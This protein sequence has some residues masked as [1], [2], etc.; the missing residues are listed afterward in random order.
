MYL[1]LLLPIISGFIAQTIKFFIKTNQQNFSFKKIAAYS[2]MPSG[3]SAMVV[4]LTAIAGLQEGF[5]SPIFAISLILAIIV[6]RDALGIR[7]YLGIHGKTLNILVKD[8]KEDKELF[9]S[10]QANIAVCFQDKYARDVI[11]YK[12]RG[13]IHKISNEAAKNFLNLLMRDQKEDE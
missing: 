11:K 7:R 4:S 6:I 8:L 13:D 1:I 5:D 2:G 10:W 12:N 3:H 9:Y